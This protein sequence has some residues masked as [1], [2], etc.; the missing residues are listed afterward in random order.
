MEVKPEPN[1]VQPRLENAASHPQ[2]HG[3]SQK[4]VGHKSRLSKVWTKDS[5]E[6]LGGCFLPAEGNIFHET[7]VWILLLR[8]LLMPLNCVRTMSYPKMEITN[9][10]TT[11][12]T[13]VRRL[14]IVLIATKF[15]NREYND[16]LT[17]QKEFSNMLGAARKRGTEGLLDRAL[18]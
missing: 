18:L 2:L 3:C 6:S 15:K 17:V 14:K 7:D 11:N 1:S 9:F 13:Q 4:G 16:R 5:S 8:L 10:L 12:H